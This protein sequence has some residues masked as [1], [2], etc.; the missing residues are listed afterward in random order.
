[1]TAEGALSFEWAVE[2][3]IGGRPAC[4]ILL[5]F[6][7][8]SLAP[9]CY[10]AHGFGHRLGTLWPRLSGLSWLLIGTALA[11]SLIRPLLQNLRVHS[12][13]QRSTTTFFSV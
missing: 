1:M 5:V 12:L 4:F 6:G 7:L 2:V 3:G 10:A 11:W 8:A 9:T 13:G